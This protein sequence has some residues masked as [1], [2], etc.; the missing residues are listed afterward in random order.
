MTADDE[1]RAVLRRA[2]DR[3]DVSPVPMPLLLQEGRRARRRRT[4]AVVSTCLAAVLVVAGG[5]ALAVNRIGGETTRDAAAPHATDSPSPHHPTQT[6]PGSGP[7]SVPPGTRLVGFNGI[8]IAVP[9]E[10]STNG[11][12]CHNAMEDT[13]IVG[14]NPGVDCG[15]SVPPGDVS[16]A[17]LVSHAHDLWAPRYVRWDVEATGSVGGSSFV[18]SPTRP[19]SCNGAHCQMFEGALSFKDRDVTLWVDSPSRH[20][21][22]SVLDSVFVLPRGFGAIPDNA[23]PRSLTRRGF[24]VHEQVAYRP[25]LVAGWLLKTTPEVGTIVARGS[26]VMLTH[27]TR[28]AGDPCASLQVELVTP[29]GPHSVSALSRESFTVR[30]HA[31]ESVSVQALG[32]CAETVSASSDDESV[33]R[34]S[35]GTAFTAVAPG[36]TGLDIGIP[37]CAGALPSANCRGGL[38]IFAAV[39]VVVEP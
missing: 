16:S 28:V 37:M 22:D 21:I 19:I 13:V 23:T 14:D 38:S 32:A 25:R 4:S 18:R 26:T 34:G 17:H 31:G 3:I 20:T 24:A 30:V 1:T 9:V 29:A 5:T 15:F 39:T 11:G 33:L 10:W 6:V 7:L 8:G 35:D 36:T 27:S 12:V 2:G